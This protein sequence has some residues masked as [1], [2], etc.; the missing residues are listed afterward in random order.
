MGK[1][2]GKFKGEKVVLSNAKLAQLGGLGGA[3]YS[4]Q[5]NQAANGLS[6]LMDPAASRSEA[7]K[8]FRQ[9]DEPAKKLDSDFPGLDEQPV[10]KKVEP[11]KAPAA[12]EKSEN[13]K[14][15]V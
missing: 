11:V 14:E 9:A 5:T 15:A 7:L 8:E 13:S 3:Q 12:V 2:K 6:A 10:T 1:R 4:T